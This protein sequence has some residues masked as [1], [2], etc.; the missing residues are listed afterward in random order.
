[1]KQT[2]TK[3]QTTQ[4]PQYISFQHIKCV[5]LTVLDKHTSV[6]WEN[7]FIGNIQVYG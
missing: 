1:M 5:F 3:Q 4:N 6:E 7:A 2:T